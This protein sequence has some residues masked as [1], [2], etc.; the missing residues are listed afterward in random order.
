MKTRARD[1]TAWSALSDAV[2]IPEVSLRVTELMYHPVDPPVGSPYEDDDFEFIEVATSA[3][4][5]RP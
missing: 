2:L 4:L 5:A 3:R 1:G